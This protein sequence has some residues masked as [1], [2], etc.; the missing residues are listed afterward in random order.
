MAVSDQLHAEVA[1]LPGK[2][3]NSTSQNDILEEIGWEGVHWTH[4]TQNRGQWRALMNTVMN[5]RVPYRQVI[6]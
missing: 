1:L 2:E 6:S 5:L 3:P 4:R